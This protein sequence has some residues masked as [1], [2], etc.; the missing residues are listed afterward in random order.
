MIIFQGLWPNTYT[1]VDTNIDS[2]Y[3]S[4]ILVAIIVVA[5]AA[6]TPKENIQ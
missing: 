3:S 4:T 6:L 2:T 1:G 5:N